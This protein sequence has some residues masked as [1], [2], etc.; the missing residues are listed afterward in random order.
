VLRLAAQAS[1]SFRFYPI[2]CC[3]GFYSDRVKN[4]EQVLTSIGD[5]VKPSCFA[6]I[7]L[8]EQLLHASSVI[9]SL[10]RGWN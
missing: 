5:R 4:F 2:S 3:F 9:V 7:G 10:I 8:D 6:Q 1:W